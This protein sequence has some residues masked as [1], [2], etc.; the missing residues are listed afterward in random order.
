[1]AAGDIKQNKRRQWHSV[2]ISSIKPAHPAI[3]GYKPT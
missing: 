1:L 3:T 2:I